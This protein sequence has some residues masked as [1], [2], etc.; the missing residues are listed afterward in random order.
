MREKDRRPRRFTQHAREVPGTARP[1]PHACQCQAFAPHA[2]PGPSILQYL[3]V[4]PFQGCRHVSVVIVIAKNGEDA[5][6][7]PE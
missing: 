2:E 7:R 6:W 1:E 5:V 4:V 3:D